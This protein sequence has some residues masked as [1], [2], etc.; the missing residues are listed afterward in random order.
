[1]QREIVDRRGVACLMDDV[2]YLA[3]KMQDGKRGAANAA[4]DDEFTTFVPNR[5]DLS[6]D[7]TVWEFVYIYD[8]GNR[9]EAA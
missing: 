3:F 6:Y 2:V 9:I 1:M 4:G 7:N 5:P 8:C